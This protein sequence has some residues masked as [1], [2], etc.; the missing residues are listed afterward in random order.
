MISWLFLAPFAVS[1]AVSVWNRKAGYVALAVSSAILLAGSFIHFDYIDSF[2]IIASLVWIFSSW[3]SV[4]YGEKYG[5]WLAPMFGST[6]FGMVV[7]LLSRNYLEFLAGWETMSVS[8]YVLIAMNKKNDYPP[9]VF[10]A[11]SEL[12]TVLIVA[13][14]IYS[15]YLTGGTTMAFTT[16]NSVIPLVLFTLGALVK[17]GMV[18]FMISEWLPIAHGNAPANGSAILSAT[19]TLMGVFGIVRIMLLSPISNIF[20][21]IVIAIGVLSVI[22]ASLFAY[23][24]EHAKMLAG[25]ST[26]ENNGAILA[27]IGFYMIAET[28]ILRDF[29]LVVIVIFSLSH[30]LSKTGLF[31]GIGAS[32][33]EY[34]LDEGLSSSRFSRVGELLSTAS[35]SGL[36]PTI[37]GL[38]TWMILEMFFMGAS[39]LGYLGIVSIIAG[40]LI[41]I[42]EGFATAAMMKAFVFTQ[43]RNGNNKGKRNEHRAVFAIGIALIL[44]FI[45]SPLFV[46]SEFLGGLPSIFVFNGFTIQSRF[47]AADF[48]LISP[49][50]VFGLLAVFSLAT[51]VIFRKPDT[52]SV[53]VWMGGRD[54]TE[55]YT[56]YAFSNNIRM[57]LKKILRPGIGERSQYMAISDAFWAFMIVLTRSYR[58]VA[59][60]FTLGFMNSSIRW[61]IIYMI[62]AFMIVLL[63][64]ILI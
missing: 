46:G 61:Y 32:G 51:F 33:K 44:L 25:F 63:L 39:F 28:S 8:S 27:A 56:P 50:Y 43:I 13:G 52:R 2:A 64:T 57:M 47:S 59:K 29:S 34:F 7:I 16:V 42:G 23:V 48:G 9:F 22:F 4:S 49:D 14:A 10:M 45:L 36:F 17:M 24:S 62:L 37:G 15:F 41:A 53:T 26:I 3:F 5:K 21:V 40:S 38:G 60:G 12:S 6:I 11:F 30:S 18:P 54:M 35:L 1:V 55:N 31:L 58:K 20:G 19:M